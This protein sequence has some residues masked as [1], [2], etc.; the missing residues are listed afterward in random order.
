MHVKYL[1]CIGDED[2]NIWRR[3][4]N[5]MRRIEKS[6]HEARESVNK[7]SKIVYSI[8]HEQRDEYMVH[9]LCESKG[10]VIVFI[11][12]IGHLDGILKYWNDLHH[13]QHGK[14]L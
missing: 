4:R 14:L 12:G 2:V 7:Y 11:V 13:I 10:D 8:L 9:K 5:P 6:R 1:F 3:E